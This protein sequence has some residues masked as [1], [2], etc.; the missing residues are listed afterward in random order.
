MITFIN[1]VIFSAALVILI[2]LLIHL[3][4]RQKRKKKLFSSLHFLRLI[5]KQKLRRINLYQY[6]LLLLR[7]LIFIFLLLAFARPTFVAQTNFLDASART[8]SIIILD[9]GI[10][11]QYYDQNGRR[12]D[13]AVKKIGEIK[14]LFET[15]DEAYIIESH[16]AV[17]SRIDS[18]DLGKCNSGFE[19]ANWSN[20]FTEAGKIFKIH[21]NFN[22]E[23]FLV[24]DNTYEITGLE[25]FITEN[26]ARLYFFQIGDQT[27]ENQ[28]IDSVV[29][30]NHIFEI[31][32]PIDLQ[33]SVVNTGSDTERSVEV[34]LY[35][36]EKRET[37]Q[38]VK[39]GPNE[40]KIVPLSFQPHQAGFISGYIEINDDALLADNRYYFNLKIPRTIDVLAVSEATSLYINPALEAI[41]QY[42]NIKIHFSDQ[43]QW[44]REHFPAYQKLLLVN[45]LP[46]DQSILSRIGE[47]I[48]AGGEVI[49][50][51]GENSSPDMINQ[52]LSKIQSRC[53]VI[54]YRQLS[55][56]GTS[57][58]QLQEFDITMPLFK[59]IYRNNFP[60]ISLPHFLKYF[61]IKLSP[62]AYSLL[63]FT[64]GDPFLISEEIN[65][66]RLILFS[67]FFSDEWG[68]LQ[69]RGLFIPL[70]SRLLSSVYYN[71]NQL[72]TG[73][74]IQ[75]QPKPGV[76]I[77]S[78]FM[79]TP[80]NE[81]IHI[82]P[83]PD[84][85]YS[86]ISLPDFTHPGN[87]TVYTDNDTLMIFSANIIPANHT[88]D[89][90]KQ[91]VDEDVIFT[92]DQ[93]FSE[94]VIQNR[95]GFELWKIILILVLFLMVLE[96]LIIKK[97]EN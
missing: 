2:P 27:F 61:Q 8:T 92:E 55:G 84:R 43:S 95:A 89:V 28:S 23:V 56:N 11:M 32:K 96:Y 74:R 46:T 63:K 48:T 70:L 19:P 29:F 90:Q 86:S 53:R 75:F 3:F 15:E 73:S 1:S 64:T 33:V 41:N 45:H 97:A 49:F 47:Y 52:F 21:P 5:E 4:N 85:Y 35:A 62:D 42:A 71:I 14:S 94:N 76:D 22:K 39:I 6:L 34:N 87:Y 20:V 9:S 18:I 77:N 38:S 67:S 80:A 30:S 25:N 72:N 50:M 26:E 65:T 81:N 54:D 69:Y 93:M 51:P 17:S 40:K 16:N 37:F 7:S 10:N 79:R 88:D 58:F 82:L 31:N 24:S 60:E 91:F 66:G 83:D 68:D 36:N 78:I 44:G 13:R 12:F 57:S 59:N